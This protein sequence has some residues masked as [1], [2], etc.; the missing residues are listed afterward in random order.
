MK[1]KKNLQVSTYPEVIQND[2]GK[3]YEVQQL[4]FVISNSI[5]RVFLELQK[6]IFLW[7]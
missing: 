7:H 3:V 4:L 2:N 1:I 6:T 5:S